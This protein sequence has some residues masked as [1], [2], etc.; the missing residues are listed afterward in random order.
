MG[1]VYGVDTTKEVTPVMVRDAL[2]RCFYLAHKD[3]TG[4][5]EQGESVNEDYCL[6][7]VKKLFTETGGDFDN[8]TK[9]GLIKLVERLKE[10]SKPFRDDRVID[11][12]ER[13]IGELIALVKE[14]S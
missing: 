9:T 8:P 12:H 3:D 10:F 13:E 14:D 11:D 1:I 7:L 2:V 6:K 5:G 4:L